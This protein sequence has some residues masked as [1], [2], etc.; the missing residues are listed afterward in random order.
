M[1]PQRLGSDGRWLVV[2]VDHPL[3]SWPCR[4]LEDRNRLLESVTAAGADAVIASYG[5]IRDCRNSFGNAAPILKLD[6][7]NVYLGNAYPVS[8]FRVSWRIDDARRLGVRHVLTYVQLGSPFELEAL[9]AAARIASDADAAEMTYI[10]ELIPVESERF[11]DPYAPVAVAAAAR[12]GAEIGAHVVKTSLPEPIA[13]LAEATAFEVPVIVVGGDPL[14]DAELI[15]TR[16]AAALDAGAA[17]A[18]VGRNVWGAADPAGVVERLRQVVH[19]V[20]RSRAV[21]DAVR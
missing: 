18:A 14:K 12:T 8:E 20:A 10:C 9:Q 4:G 2:A 7:S 3:Y 5:T 21:G 1:H 19:P 13:G 11:G 15:V 6:L 16:V 17:G